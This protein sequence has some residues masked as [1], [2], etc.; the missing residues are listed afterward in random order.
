MLWKHQQKF[1]CLA[2]IKKL[3][4]I[5]FLTCCC[6]LNAQNIHDKVPLIEVLNHLE[7]QYP[8][9]F[10]YAPKTIEGLLVFYPPEHLSFQQVLLNLENQTAFKFT[11]LPNNF[12]SIT[13]G[14]Y[15]ERIWN[16]S[17]HSEFQ[18]YETDYKLKGSNA[19]IEENQRFLQENQVS[20]TGTKLN[21][22]YKINDNITFLN[23]YEFIET[24][25]VNFEDVD[26]PVYSLYVA[27]VL[28]KHSLYSQINFSSENNKTSLN[29]GI[30]AN[31]IGKFD[32]F[33]AEPRIS[34]NQKLQKH[35]NLEILGEFK[36][37]TTSQ[38]IN[39]QN[40][41]LGVEERRWQL[42]NNENIPV[43][44]SKQLSLGLQFHKNGW[45]INAD[46]YF[47]KVDGITTQ[48]QGFQNQYLLARTYGS[49]QV[50]G[51]DFLL[52]KQFNS[53][54][55]WLSYSYANNTY[56][57]KT[58]QNTSFPNNLNITNSV[59]FGSSYSFNNFKISTGF[60]WHSGIPT[61]NPIAGNDIENDEINYEPANS[62]RLNDYFRIDFSSTYRFNLTN[63]TAADV[64]LSILNVSNH[65]NYINNYYRINNNGLVE[66]VIKSSLKFTPNLSF[67]VTF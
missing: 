58:L 37:Q 26:N 55:T 48:S 35:L 49:Y 4:F 3:F 44:L 16:D 27:E 13:G 23:G 22:F 51:L 17:F 63:N 67:R 64:G 10:N 11:I 28:R 52:K 61:T 24:Q 2:V 25:V 5:L 33:I 20:E 39:F 56:L 29:A 12:V 31:Y 14:L 42:S 47:K 15:Y 50:K 53:L 7:K 62:S 46:G 9:H 41:F 1:H 57:F 36:H 18:I 34:F 60:N 66:E 65:K 43:I 40:D 32:K 54:N 38:I 19:N 21:T 45:L 59:T 8:F 6:P 30:R